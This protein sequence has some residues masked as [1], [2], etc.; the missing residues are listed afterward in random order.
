MRR[1][2]FIAIAT[3]LAGTATTVPAT[4]RTMDALTLTEA[5]AGLAP[6][7][8]LWTDNVADGPISVLISVPDQRAYVFKGQT[9]IAASAVS[10]GKEGND[11]PIGT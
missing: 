11:T 3:V 4:A 5:A 9:L 7:R 1:L 2:A 8:F 6:G 10:T